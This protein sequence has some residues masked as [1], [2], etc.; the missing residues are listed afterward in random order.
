MHPKIVPRLKKKFMG[1]GSEF[2][3]IDLWPKTVKVLLRRPVRSAR[4][5]AS[6]LQMGSGGSLQPS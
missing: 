5:S 4:T 6:Q 2:N 1:S 3:E